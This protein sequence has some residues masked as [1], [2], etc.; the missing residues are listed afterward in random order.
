MALAITALSVAPAFADGSGSSGDSLLRAQLVGSSPAPASPVIAGVNPGG[1]PWVNG[2]S[3][4]R[5]R[6]D[7]RI[8]VTIEGLV[9]PKV[10]NPI[11][12]VAATLVCGQTLGGSTAPFNLSPAG[13]GSTR[14]VISVPRD[15][16][17]PAVLIRVVQPDGTRGA[18]I[19]SAFGKDGLET[20][21]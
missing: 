5:V 15:C 18:Y 4:V 9:I 2:P 6:E 11:A 13:N 10:G 16:E 21:G 1:K 20:D 14:D 3:Q 17:N 12:R 8:K 7:G 19:A